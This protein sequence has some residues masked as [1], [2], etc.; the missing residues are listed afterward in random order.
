PKPPAPR[1]KAES[2]VRLRA[3][4]MPSARVDY[5]DAQELLDEFCE[6]QLALSMN[7]ACLEKAIEQAPREPASRAAITTL[8]ARCRDI[9][10]LRDSLAAIHHAS[11][12]RSVQRIFVTDS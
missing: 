5:L 11:I 8:E 3:L 2:H 7:L 4:P 9:M 1:S 6:E 12:D 10:T